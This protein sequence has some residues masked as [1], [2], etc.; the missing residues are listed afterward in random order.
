MK[1]VI[2]VP[3][4]H[5]IIPWKFTR[6]LIDGVLNLVNNGIQVKVLMTEGSYIDDNKTKLLAKALQH[7]PDYIIML[8]WD[9][10]F[11]PDDLQHLY[12][13]AKDNNLDLCSGLYFIDTGYK[14]PCLIVN[15]LAYENYP[16]DSLFEVDTFGAGF[17]I[18]SYQ[19]AKAIYEVEGYNRIG[20]WGEDVSFCHRAKNVCNFKIWC[21]SRIKVGHLRFQSI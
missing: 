15:G 18:M 3:V 11:D 13:T 9:H 20:N 8:D 2:G 12:E 5:F 7:E 1:I 6:S 14:R 4:G 10:T 16:E 21:D 19:A 17:S